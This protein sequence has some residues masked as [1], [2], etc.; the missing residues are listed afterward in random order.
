MLVRLPV[1]ERP[2]LVGFAPGVTATLSNVLPPCKTEDGVAVPTPDGFV[3]PPA[4]MPKIDMSS[5]A[6]A[7]AFVVVEPEHTE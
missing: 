7:C 3:E 1:T 2:L 4:E 6:S 5:M